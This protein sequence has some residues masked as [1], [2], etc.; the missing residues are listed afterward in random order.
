MKQQMSAKSI[1]L[2]GTS[3][4]VGKSIL[5]AG[6]CR[7][8]SQEGFRVA[9]FKSQNITQNTY[10]L[11]DGGEIGIAQGIQA[12]AAGIQPSAEMNPLLLQPQEKAATRVIVKGKLLGE[13]DAWAYRKNYYLR[14]L[15]VIKKAWR[16][17]SRENEILIIEGAGS[18]AEINLKDRDLANMQVALLAGSPV[19]LVADIDRGGAFAALIGTLALLEPGERELVKG[20]IINKFRGERRLLQPALDFLEEKTGLPV[21]GVIPFLEDLDIEEEDSGVAEGGEKFSAGA[22][23]ETERKKRREKSYERLAA[24][25]REQLDLRRLYAMMGL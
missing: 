15:E 18:P 20:F 14:G 9:P 6:L 17:L 22:S 24:M 4:H 7:L 1:M 12:E 5:A 23:G 25:L 8:F 2:Q 19:I 3:S 10:R 13:M 21:L 11:A 16:Q